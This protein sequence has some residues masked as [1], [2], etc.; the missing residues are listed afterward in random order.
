M[1]VGRVF[2]LI[3]A[4]SLTAETTAASLLL[5]GSG[6]GLVVVLSLLLA[7]LLLLLVGRGAG[8]STTTACGWTVNVVDHAFWNADTSTIPMIIANTLYS[9][10][11]ASPFQTIEL[12]D[13]CLRLR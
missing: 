9:N 4:T 7:T 12:N 11:F 3:A 6:A 10:T 5:V 13:S 2:I 1:M 8:S